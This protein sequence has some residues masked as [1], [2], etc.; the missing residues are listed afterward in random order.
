MKE[1][2]PKIS[3]GEAKRIGAFVAVKALDVA[4]TIYG[5]HKNLPEQVPLTRRIIEDYGNVGLTLYSLAHIAFISGA[6]LAGT[7]IEK[8]ITKSQDHKW[9]DRFMLGLILVQTAVN[10]HNLINISLNRQ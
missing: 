9:A 8:K 7:K 2:L 6:Y 10:I 3:Q 4:T 1:R 5:L